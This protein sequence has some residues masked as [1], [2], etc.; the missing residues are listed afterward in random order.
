MLMYLKVISII[1]MP[2]SDFNA[3]F[4]MWLLRRVAHYTWNTVNSS[5]PKS[6]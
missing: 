5:Q 4:D 6:A 1:V 2:P 3:N